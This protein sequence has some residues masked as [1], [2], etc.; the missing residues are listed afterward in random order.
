M[1]EFYNGKAPFLMQWAF[2]QLLH[3]SQ[4]GCTRLGGD[5]DETISSRAGRA[6]NAGVP[7]FNY[8]FAPFINWIFQD[9]SHN[10]DAFEPDE[11][12]VKEIW[13][14]N[15]PGL[16]LGNILLLTILLAEIS[17]KLF[18]WCLLFKYIKGVL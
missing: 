12:L 13:D 9:N 17:V 11:S 1:H 14:W 8:Y 7:F 15:Q 3:L 2:N 5:P 18:M 10:D 6:S 16:D 4:W